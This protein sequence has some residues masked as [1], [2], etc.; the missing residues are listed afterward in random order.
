MIDDGNDVMWEMLDEREK[1]DSLIG[2]V[3]IIFGIIS[4]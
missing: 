4:R 1:C 3:T 2:F